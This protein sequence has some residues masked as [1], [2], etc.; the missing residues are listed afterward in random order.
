MKNDLKGAVSM[1]L[2]ENISIKKYARFNSPLILSI[3]IICILISLNYL[4]SQENYAILALILLGLGFAFF[5]LVYAS[6][7]KELFKAF[8]I[9]TV[10]FYSYRYIMQW[11]PPGTTIYETVTPIYVRL[12]KDI[13]WIGF[14]LLVLN[15]WAYKSL[16]K[17]EKTFD[18]SNSQKGFLLLVG[19][20]ILYS[21]LILPLVHFGIKDTFRVLLYEIRYPIEYIFIIFLLPIFYKGEDDLKEF[22]KIFFYLTIY[23][24][25]FLIYEMFLGGHK[26]GFYIGGYQVRY[27][28]AFGSP[29]DFGLYIGMILLLF[30]SLL[31]EGYFLKRIF[32]IFFIIACFMALLSTVSLSA[33]GVSLIGLFLVLFISLG[34]VK[35]IVYSAPVFIPLAL[36]VKMLDPYKYL[37][38]KFFG[39]FSGE[40]VSAVGRVESLY[41]FM[42]NLS[43][44]N[45]VKFLFGNYESVLSFETFYFSL[46]Y[47]KGILALIFLFIIVFVTFIVGMK[48]YALARKFKNK[49]LQGIFLG[50]TIFI[51]MFTLANFGI[52]Y[53]NNFPLNFYF[54]FWTGIIWFTPVTPE[55]LEVKV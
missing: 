32:W 50:S 28:S 37:L 48:K 30:T 33:I 39:I 46:I 6:K 41:S 29:N 42:D 9:Y 45:I 22:P 13:V 4:I 5:I 21:G 43:K 49:F 53:F 16:L 1:S 8:L 27:G 14:I 18:L 10:I 54:W 36:I 2:L 40:N 20:Y 23:T 25:I 47:N 12:I 34:P 52:P 7:P 31:S 15:F 38:W 17:R 11:G 55:K 44:T 24:L 26:T 19:V 35:S 51:T 3:A